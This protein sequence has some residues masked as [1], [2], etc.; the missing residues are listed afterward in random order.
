MPKFVVK[1]DAP[2]SMNQK[3]V[4]VYLENLGEYRQ[5]SRDNVPV[6]ANIDSY[7]SN[8]FATLWATAQPLSRD[9]WDSAYEGKLRNQYRTIVL[10]GIVELRDP[11]ATLVSV[12]A[13]METALLAT[14]K[15]A[16]YTKVKTLAT[17]ST[18]VQRD[19]FFNLVAFLAL[20]DLLAD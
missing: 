16:A 7:V 20:N 2:N 13:A 3:R 17:A 12:T 14:D 15:A 9:I 8:N 18:S 19:A 4:T 11:T 10:A 5:I 6:S 1:L